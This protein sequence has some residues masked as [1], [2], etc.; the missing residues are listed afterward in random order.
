MT[1]SIT[2]IAEKLVEVEEVIPYTIRKKTNTSLTDGKTK[3]IQEGKEGRQK[4]VYK[5]LYKNGEEL[6]RDLVETVIIEEAVDKIVEYGTSRNGTTASIRYQT[7]TLT[8]RGESIRYKAVM[9]M[10]AS[11]YDACYKCTGKS[12]GMRGYGITA[13]GLKAGHG[14]I[15]VDPRVIPLGTRLYVESLDGSWTYGYAIAADTGGAIKQ[16]RIDLCMETHSEALKSGMRNA[17]V[18]ILE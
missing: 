10:R 18:Y 7:G 14:I 5:I 2:R 17:R 11:A 9:E 3:V 8:S 15:A 12:P 4:K 16:N 13:S 6:S 1:I